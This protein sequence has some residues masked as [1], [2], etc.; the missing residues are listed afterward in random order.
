MRKCFE[1]CST[2]DSVAVSEI[3]Q[4]LKANADEDVEEEDP[5]CAL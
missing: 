5:L 1:L 3:G 2:P 4:Q